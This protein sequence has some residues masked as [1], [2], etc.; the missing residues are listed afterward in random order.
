MKNQSFNILVA[1]DDEAIRFVVSVILRRHG[2]TVEV[3]DNG[4]EAIELFALKPDYFDVLITDHN[5]PL[6]SGLELVHYLRKNGAQTRIIVISANLT[7]EL[8]SAYQNKCVD[9]I[10]QKPFTQENLSF[11]LNDILKQWK[12]TAGA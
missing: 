11:A 9:K 12:G 3:V 4:N 7:S 8:I 2:H 5:M 1:D 6:V 10:L